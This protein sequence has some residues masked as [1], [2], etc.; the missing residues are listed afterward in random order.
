MT[1]ARKKTFDRTALGMLAV[2][3]IA[4]T[5]FSNA[6]LSGLRIDLTENKLYT[7]SQGTR[8]I[9]ANID[10]P[11]NLYFFFSD[12]ATENIQQIRMQAVR[13]REIRGQRPGLGPRTRRCSR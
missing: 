7:I 8:N 6:L 11:I 13:V 5:L 12:R 10:E 1:E 4:V 9:L 2:L 3:F